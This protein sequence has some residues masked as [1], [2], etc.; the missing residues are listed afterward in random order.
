[1]VTILGSCGTRLHIICRISA[2]SLGNSVKVASLSEFAFDLDLADRFD[3]VM[4]VMREL[5]TRMIDEGK[6]LVKPGRCDRKV[7]AVN[8]GILVDEVEN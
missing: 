5:S 6:D 8:V 7:L 1:M 4:V 3:S 2:G